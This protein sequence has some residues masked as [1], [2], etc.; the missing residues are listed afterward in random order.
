MTSDFENHAVIGSIIFFNFFLKIGETFACLQS[1]GTSPRTSDALKISVSI[2]GI[3]LLYSFST[4]AF[5]P[6]VPA[7]LST[8]SLPNSLTTPF[9]PTVMSTIEEN[10]QSHFVDSS[11]SASR[12]YVFTI[13]AQKFCLCEPMV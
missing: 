3:P 4:L 2:R 1:F 11:E 9:G 7:A 5:S 13:Y 6:S 12:V 10:R 8:F